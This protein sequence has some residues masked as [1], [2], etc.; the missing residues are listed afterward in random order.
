MLREGSL[1]NTAVGDVLNLYLLK[2]R[3]PIE[4]NLVSM[5]YLE[6]ICFL[7]SVGDNFAL[8]LNIYWQNLAAIPVID[9]T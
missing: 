6:D 2:L 4:L 1:G 5:D 7:P 9:L 3:H 8:K